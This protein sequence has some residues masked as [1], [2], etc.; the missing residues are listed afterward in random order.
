MVEIPENTCRQYCASTSQLVD[1]P[2]ENVFPPAPPPPP[3][4]PR[5]PTP[6]SPQIDVPLGSAMQVMPALQN[7]PP[8][9]AQHI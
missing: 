1:G 4:P 3:A 5:P 9:P 7:M 6:L 8:S 2:H